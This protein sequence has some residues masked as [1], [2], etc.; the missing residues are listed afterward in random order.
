[1]SAIAER[2]LPGRMGPRPAQ[3]ADG[4]ERAPAPCSGPVLFARYAYG[5]NRLG[6]CGPDAVAELFG[7]GTTGGDD[8]ALRQ[9]APAFDGAWP[10][11]ELIARANGI[12]D[13]LDRRVVEA[14]WLGNGLL[15]A[16]DEEELG[17]SLAVRFRPRLRP[18]GWRWLAT[19][20][21]RGA[22]PVHSF[23]V[24]DV[25]PRIGLLRTGSVDRAL[26]VM[27]SC[28]IRWGRVLERD[29]DSLVVDVVPL[30]LVDGRLALGSPR[31][32]RIQAWSDGAGFV[33][34]DI[35]AGDV[36]SVH[37][38]FACDRLGP[39]QLGGLIRSTAAEIDLA[40]ETI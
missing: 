35:A 15:D 16:V 19:K 26:E 3:S 27:D 28:R 13:P 29:G 32:E 14:Y 38:S 6:Y 20:P 11:L 36:V 33:G 34:D 25:F 18:E 30:A 9:L 2:S 37:W 40:N 24:L 8:R 5:P 7:E 10:Y 17:A 1:M 39:R 31:P 21:G 22:V 4:P 23:H 12:A